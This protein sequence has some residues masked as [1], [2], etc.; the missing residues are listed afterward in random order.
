MSLTLRL[1][2]TYLAVTLIGM[3]LLGL[4]LSALA[5]RYLES[6]RN[7]T[8]QAQSA[9][10]AELLG[11]L[12]SDQSSLSAI[13]AGTFNRNRLSE[14]NAVRVFSNTGALLVGDPALGPFPSRP[15][16]QLINS[17]LPLPA[18]QSTGR[19]YA[20]DRIVGLNGTIGVIELSR[21][22]AADTELVTLLR[23]LA[24]QA[25]L[26]AALVIALISFILA[27]SIARPVLRTAQRAEALAAELADINT[28]PAPSPSDELARLQRS[29]DRLENG[30][31][32]YVN[33]INELEQA[34][35]HF[36]RSISH[37]L[38]TPLTAIRGTIENLSDQ[39]DSDQ[40]PALDRI[41]AEVARL[42]RLVDDLLRPPDDG[43]LQ[44]TNR[45]RLDLAQLAADLCS[46]LEGRAVRAGIRLDCRSSGAAEILGDR[47]RLK[48][49]LLNLIDNALRVTP[50][51]GKVLVEVGA[52][53]NGVQLIVSDS[54][55]GI[56]PEL[57][58]AIWER[59]TRGENPGSAGLGLAI[60]REIVVAH[61]GQIILDPTYQLGARFVI[62][63]PHKEIS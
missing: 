13:A 5:E 52:G 10:Y 19:S 43:R 53:N 39:A 9:I 56:A 45:R 63:L 57:Q 40:R 32:H 7:T 6:Q 34:R 47:D 49:A 60:S 44:L 18:S 62:R 36:Y 11:E 35:N 50:P 25:A 54:G 24:F 3:L 17:P 33:R 46:L 8:L 21:S 38:R 55:P 48:Q 41:D 58:A 27:R 30:F 51:G 26:G 23:R 20:A 4:G 61:G 59:G 14:G 31:R 12:A 15:A 16:L 1:A 28:A 37:E 2:L 29:L 42:S 22:T